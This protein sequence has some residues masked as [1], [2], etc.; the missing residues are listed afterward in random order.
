MDVWA[1]GLAMPEPVGTGGEQGRWLRKGEPAPDRNGG[2]QGRD[3]VPW[4]CR[5]SRRP[6]VLTEKGHRGPTTF[7]GLSLAPCS[8]GR[9]GQAGRRADECAVR[10]SCA[11]G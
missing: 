1:Q 11:W 8:G 7:C 6:G 4:M 3:V 5:L 10:G 9:R 2:Q